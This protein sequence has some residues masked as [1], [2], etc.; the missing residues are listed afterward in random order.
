MTYQE[1]YDSSLFFKT[2]TID[3]LCIESPVLWGTIGFKWVFYQLRE[4]SILRYCGIV[5]NAEY[6]APL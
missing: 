4:G 6:T 2:N 1:K 5:Q 3:P